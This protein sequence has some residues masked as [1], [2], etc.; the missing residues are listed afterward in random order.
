MANVLMMRVST[1]P[2]C[3]ERQEVLKEYLINGEIKE[4]KTERINFS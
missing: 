2:Q 3:L 1:Q 4:F